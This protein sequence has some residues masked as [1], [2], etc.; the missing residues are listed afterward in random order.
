MGGGKEA[1]PYG[2]AEAWVKHTPE[3]PAKGV[4]ESGSGAAGL[5]YTR[6]NVQSQADALTRDQLDHH[7][8]FTPRDHSPLAG[9]VLVVHGR[10]PGCRCPRG[11]RPLR[12]V[13]AP[14]VGRIDPIV[15]CGWV[16][17]SPWLSLSS[18][19]ASSSPGSRAAG[20]ANR[21]HRPVASSGRI[22][23]VGWEERHLPP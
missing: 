8:H 15:P 10:R 5:W 4:P 11:W 1:T 9:V 17:P 2:E 12:L 21:P 3:H 7:D 16:R 6:C 13:R 18:G 22:L 14:P 23:V 19:V 20:R